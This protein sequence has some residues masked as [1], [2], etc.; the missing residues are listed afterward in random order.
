M[1]LQSLWPRAPT[2]GP[3]QSGSGLKGELS[4]LTRPGVQEAAGVL[5]E[6]RT[7]WPGAGHGDGLCGSGLGVRGE[8][9]SPAS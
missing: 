4:A 8:Q 2:W 1:W 5:P 3:A 6:A 9:R 7:A